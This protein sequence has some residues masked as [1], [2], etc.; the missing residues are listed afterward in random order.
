[1][2]P[3]TAARDEMRSFFRPTLSSRILLAA[4][5]LVAGLLVPRT[6][7]A[8]GADKSFVFTGWVDCGRRSETRCPLG[9]TLTIWTD[10]FGMRQKV[11]I[12]L[13]WIVNALEPFDQDDFVCIEVSSMDGVY[14]A[15]ALIT[16]K[17]DDK[18]KKSQEKDSA[19]PTPLP[20]ST[21]TPGDSPQK[22]TI[23]ITNVA[24]LLTGG[25]MLAAVDSLSTDGGTLA[26]GVAVPPSFEGDPIAF[27][28]TLSSPINEQVKVD[29]KTEDITATGAAAC[30]SFA[31]DT[32][33]VK[34][35]GTLTFAPNQTVQT[36]LVD[37]CAD[38]AQEPDETLK[39]VLSNPSSNAVI[40]INPAI[41]TITEF[42]E[43]QVEEP[44]RFQAFQF[45]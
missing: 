25:P 39:M 33:Y 31:G 20:T 28:V 5:L 41:G 11:T 19:T 34:R 26:F 29:Y 3:Y 37:T 6:E 43:C 4:F 14:Q 38:D 24:P 12:D 8:Q 1:M 44:N 23:N 18:K 9:N 36:L 30:T 17:N 15:T 7:P 27:E 32:D 35:S 10:D 22:V 13:S 45:C 2:I 21:R 40:G 16:C 42:N